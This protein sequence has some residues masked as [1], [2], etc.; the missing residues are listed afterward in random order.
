MP[1][2]LVLILVEAVIGG[3]VVAGTVFF[4]V[5]RRLERRVA[6]AAGRSAQQQSERILSEAKREGEATR[7]ESIL[8]AKEEII[9]AREVWEQEAH[10]RRDEIDRHERRLEERETLIDRKLNALDERDK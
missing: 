1:T 8:A 7:A 6:E 10:R 9:K 3:A 2:D 5:G 4:V